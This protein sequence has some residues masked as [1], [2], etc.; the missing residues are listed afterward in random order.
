MLHLSPEDAEKH[1][2]N[3]IFKNMKSTKQKKEVLKDKHAL[4]GFLGKAR[5]C[6]TSSGWSW[7]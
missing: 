2:E 6:K 1:F 5:S 3:E 7:V 4:S